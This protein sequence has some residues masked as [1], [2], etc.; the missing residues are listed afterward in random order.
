MVPY[1]LARPALEPESTE[2]LRD[3]IRGKTFLTDQVDDGAAD[4][5]FCFGGDKLSVSDLVAVRRNGRAEVAGVR[6]A[7]GRYAF[8]NSERVQ[9][10]KNRRLRNTQLSGDL[11]GR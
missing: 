6:R 4:S 5:K 7:T 3:G 1:R 10:G 9:P 11:R 2:F 8:A